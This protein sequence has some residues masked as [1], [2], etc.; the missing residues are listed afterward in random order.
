MRP[1]AVDSAV[2]L[3]SLVLVALQVTLMQALAE[4]Q[5]H[6]FAYVV[7]ALALLGFGGSGTALSL[8]RPRAL[9]RG[10]R[11]QSDLLLSAGMGCIVALPL[12]RLAAARVDFPLLF[13]DWRAW[14]PLLL[15]AGLACVPFFLGAL[16]LGLAF[17][18][19]TRSIGRLYAANLLGSAA[20]AATGLGLLFWLPAERVFPFM[21]SVLACAALVLAP[22]RGRAAACR[23]V[24]ALG[25][26]GAW[27]M[28]GMPVSAYKPVSHAL[29]LAGAE[30]LADERHPMGRVQVVRSPALRHAPGLSLNFG[31][32]IPATGHVYVNGE[33]VGAFL[34][35]AAS[36]GHI[37]DHGLQALPLALC[38]PRR[39]LVLHAGAGASAGLLLSHQGVD[40]DAV[41]PHPIVAGL[42]RGAYSSPDGRLAVIA[43]DG[44]AFLG[45]SRRAYDLILLPPQGA[46]GG[47]IGLQALQENYLLTREGF[48]ALWNALARGEGEAGLLS[49]SVHL[50]QPPRQSLK[51]LSLSAAALREAGVRDPSRHVA[52][53]RS[54]E[55][56]AVAVSTRPFDEA[57]CRRLEDFARFGGFDRVWVPGRGPAWEDRFHLMLDDVLPY[58]F[59]AILAGDGERFVRDYPFDIAPPEDVRP[60]FHQFIRWG[61]L[62]DVRRQLG[63]DSPAFVEMG[64]ILVALTAVILA[65]AAFALILL[66]LSRLAGKGPAK[67]GARRGA[68]AVLGYF[69]AI[70][71]G[72][73]FLEIVWIQRFT[74][75]WGQPLYS[76]AGV[77]TALLCGMGV[78]S[79]LSAGVPCAPRAIRSVLVGALALIGALSV[80]LPRVMAVGLGWPEPLKWA[81][82][83]G[84][85]F[86]AA[87][88][89]G[90]PFPLALRAVSAT[91]PELVPWAWGV[92]GCFSVLAAPLAALVAM[93]GGFGAVSA[94]AAAAYLMA[95]C[96]ASLAGDAGPANGSV[97]GGKC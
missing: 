22:G 69:G 13:V 3:A 49:F 80:V 91:R 87:V 78:G 39:A 83:L 40:V 24:L 4:A 35:S 14:G 23:A 65:V 86:V 51:L 57:A 7:I 5:G 88:V 10:A 56:L 73:M 63:P 53:V 12:A 79:A 48:S 62:G 29:R 68:P 31:G 9:A 59:E 36:G 58:G 77:L 61:R 11:L 93:Q 54:W 32:E 66:P 76:A 8:L 25:V 6:H 46:F 81:V 72:F 67:G 15:S 96:S 30:V 17:M 2:F 47:G 75:F 85:L 94:V 26:A 52:A 89:F 19:D 38:A 43:M 27:L 50:D 20:G 64:T 28:P 55:M 71:L 42:L 16:F 21:G 45:W 90:L 37:L 70:G 18:R 95:F 92:N 34:P 97:C 60:Y 1:R 44:R 41:E 33:G 84:I 82:G 74:L